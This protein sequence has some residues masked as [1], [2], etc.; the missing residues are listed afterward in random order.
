MTVSRVPA[1]VQQSASELCSYTV[2]Y[3]LMKSKN[4]HCYISRINEDVPLRACALLLWHS[5][6]AWPRNDDAATFLFSVKA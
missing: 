2:S 4:P 5:L 1:T 6:A 3:L